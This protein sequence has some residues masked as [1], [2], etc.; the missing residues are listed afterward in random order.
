MAT[1]KLSEALNELTSQSSLSKNDSLIVSTSEGAAK[2]V[3]A[4]SIACD[5]LVY[6][7]GT[8]ST[9][10]EGE[11]A[12]AQEAI[13]YDTRPAIRFIGK[14]QRAFVFQI[15]FNAD[16]VCQYY[17]LGTLQFYRHI[18]IDKDATKVLNVGGW[19]NYGYSWSDPIFSI[20]RNTSDIEKNKKDIESINNSLQSFLDT[21][22]AQAADIYKI[23]KKLGIE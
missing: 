21:L 10:A 12:V 6:D 4:S 22:Q 13:H 20:N 5:S 9:G 7:L 3:P 14:G 18:K 16:Y 1:K 17:N 15:R 23:K 11:R 8:F 19:N 2:K